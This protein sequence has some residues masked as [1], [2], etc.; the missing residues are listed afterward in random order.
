MLSKQFNANSNAMSNDSKPLCRF[1]DSEPSRRFHIWICQLLILILVLIRKVSS[2]DLPTAAQRS[3]T[4]EKIIIWSGR[5]CSLKKH[6]I[7]LKVI[8]LLF[9]FIDDPDMRKQLREEFGCNSGKNKISLFLLNL[10]QN[11]PPK[12]PFLEVLCLSWCFCSA[13]SPVILF[14]MLQL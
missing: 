10:E 9:S 8:L 1:F 4:V 12:C 11:N 3:Q 2:L 6:I 14:T 5:F 7:G 13:I